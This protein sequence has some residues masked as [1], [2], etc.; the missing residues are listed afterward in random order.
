MTLPDVQI[1][2]PPG[3]LVMTPTASGEVPNTEPDVAARL[4]EMA[5]RL[6]DT[7]MVGWLGLA[8]DSEDEVPVGAIFAS[9]LGAWRVGD[10]VPPNQIRVLVDEA[11]SVGRVVFEETMTI[12]GVDS[13]WLQVVYDIHAL[14]PD[15][16]FTL[17]FSTPNLPLGET[18]IEYFDCI[19]RTVSLA[20]EAA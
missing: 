7:V 9:A 6:P 16:T 2:F 4:N 15:A 11:G 3:W 20:E 18:L 10:F 1:A 19:V 17:V 5:R 13:V 14:V 8:L 12:G